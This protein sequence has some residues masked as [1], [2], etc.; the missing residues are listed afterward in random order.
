[1]NNV[2]IFLAIISVISLIGNIIYVSNGRIKLYSSGM[3]LKN[4]TKIDRKEVKVIRFGISYHIL[5]S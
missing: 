1:M 4:F 2:N 3:I 5:S